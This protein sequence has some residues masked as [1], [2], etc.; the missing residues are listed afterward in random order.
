METEMC[1]ILRDKKN[2][3][4]LECLIQYGKINYSIGFLKRE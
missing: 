1:Y 3:F 4:I 2:L